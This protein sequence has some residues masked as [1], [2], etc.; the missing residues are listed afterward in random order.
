[1]N[2]RA[3]STYLESLLSCIEGLGSCKEE[4]ESAAA[5]A[6]GVPAVGP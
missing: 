6:A 4:E 5:Q 3:A 1:M 2:S